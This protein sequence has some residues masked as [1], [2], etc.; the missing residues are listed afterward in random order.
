MRV[1][2]VSLACCFISSMSQC[3]SSSCC[4]FLT[5]LTENLRFSRLGL[6]YTVSRFTFSARLSWIVFLVLSSAV[7]VRAATGVPAKPYLLLLIAWSIYSYKCFVAV[8]TTQYIS[9]I[10]LSSQHRRLK[11]FQPFISKHC[12]VTNQ[13]YFDYDYC[14]NYHTQP[15][16]LI[17]DLF[18]YEILS[19]LWKG[20][21]QTKC[22][23]KN[24]D[25]IVSP[26]LQKDRKEPSLPKLSRKAVD[27]FFDL[28][29]SN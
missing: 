23:K 3:S 4:S 18:K 10:T 13:K 20:K 7:P 17:V 6:T 2:G 21:L 19:T 29:Q 24:N 26:F 15:S 8:Y 9:C 5:F 16:F 11:N 25:V 22:K 12:F 28:G 1:L 27:V 14:L